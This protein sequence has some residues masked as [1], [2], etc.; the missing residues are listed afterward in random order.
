MFTNTS[1]IAILTYW[2]LMLKDAAWLGSCVLAFAINIVIITIIITITTTIAVAIAKLTSWSLVL[3]DSAWLG[4][5]CRYNCYHHHHNHYHHCHHHQ[6]SHLMKPDAEGSSTAV[7]QRADNHHQH[8]YHHDHYSNK[9]PLSPWPSSP[10]EAWH[11][12]SLHG[13]ALACWCHST[14]QTHFPAEQPGEL[15]LPCWRPCQSSGWSPVF[16]RT[17][18]SAKQIVWLI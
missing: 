17:M 9:I 10:H 6:H 3:K 5:N 16:H 8:N 13:W 14:V 11:W 12:R 18:S 2:S 15:L 7:Y 4:S 1:S